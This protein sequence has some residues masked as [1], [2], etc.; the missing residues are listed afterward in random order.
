MYKGIRGTWIENLKK[1][2]DFM[3]NASTEAL[4]PP[5]PFLGKKT[6]ESR[7]VQLQE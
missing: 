7:L 3:W 6:T 5:S 2:Y 4:S 1:V